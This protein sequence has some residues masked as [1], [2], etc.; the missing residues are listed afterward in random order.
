[1]PGLDG[2][3][4]LAA[5]GVVL[6]HFEQSRFFYGLPN[7]YGHVARLGDLSVSLFFTL[8]G[9]LITHLLF[10]ERRQTGRIGLQQ[11][12]MRRVLRIWP[13]YFFLTFLSFAVIP[14][15]GL[16]EIPGSSAAISNF[17]RKLTLYLTMSPHVAWT[18][19]DPVPYGNVLWSV[20]VE[21][22]FY[23]AWPALLLAPRRVVAVAIPATIVTLLWCRWHFQVGAAATFFQLIQFD[24]MAIGAFGALL[25]TGSSHARAHAVLR[26]LLNKHFW[27]LV[28]V[29]TAM[30]LLLRIPFGAFD[31]LIYS[32]LFLVLILNAAAEGRGSSVLD[33]IVLRYLGRI[34]YGLYCYN[35]ITLVLGLLAVRFVTAASPS[36]GAHV[37]HFA[38]GMSLTIGA[39]ALSFA[40]LE[41]PALRLKIKRFTRFQTQEPLFSRS[42]WASERN[43]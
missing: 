6:A 9:F 40:F 7:F 20:G 16:L 31:Q 27:A 19:Y 3:R 22:W 15:L 5:L 29:A 32:S 10:E 37:L 8:S 12:Y 11:F 43:P 36:A 23:F 41:R 14:H 24:C 35:W 34:S 33:N 28:L 2:I 30:A 1:L 39:A 38:L 25:W 26:L 17:W 42:H 4:A 21:E 18:F 13:L